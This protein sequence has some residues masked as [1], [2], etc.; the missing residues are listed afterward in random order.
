[1]DCRIAG[2]S[3]IRM[4]SAVRG[5][6]DQVIEAR[7]YHTFKYLK[8]FFSGMLALLYEVVK[9]TLEHV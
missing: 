2:F 9:G 7:A 4:M 8:K 3:Y 1:M 5:W 6:S